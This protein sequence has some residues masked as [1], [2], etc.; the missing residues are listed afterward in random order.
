MFEKPAQPD[1]LIHELLTRRWSTRAFT[2]EP[3]EAD[4]LR[5]ILEA[6]RW[7]PSSGNGQP[8]VFIVAPRQDTE[9]FERLGSVLNPGNAWAKKASVL[10]LSVAKLDRAPG[11]PNRHAW[12]DVGLASENMA[13]QAISMGLG[14][15]MMGGFDTEAAREVCQLPERYDPVAMMAMGYPGDPNDIED[16]TLRAKDLTPRVR[17]PQSEF[18]FHGTFGKAWE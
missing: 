3:L 6:G 12:H 2:G 4:K 16:E 8:W 18:V 14:F 15:H 1:H 7:A 10:A 17:H 9:A 5:T 11:K 13:L